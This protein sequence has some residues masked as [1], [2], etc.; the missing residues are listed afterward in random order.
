MLLSKASARVFSS[1]RRALGAPAVQRRL[2]TKTRA[3]TV[4]KLVPLLLLYNAKHRDLNFWVSLLPLFLAHRSTRLP[5]QCAAVLRLCATSLLTGA[6]AARDGGE[7]DTMHASLHLQGMAGFG[8]SACA[9]FL[10]GQ[11]RQH[12]AS[13]PLHS[14]LNVCRWGLELL[15][16]KASF[17]KG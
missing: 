11:L 9:R 6:W 7:V 13:Q 8:W 16:L 1:H 17:S 5:A 15:S 2:S 12:C 3:T 14:T 10:L 4:P